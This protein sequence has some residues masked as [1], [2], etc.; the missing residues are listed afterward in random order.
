MPHSYFSRMVRGQDGV[1][2]QPPRPISTLWKSARIDWLTSL[3][4]PSEIA[5][6][7]SSVVSPRALAG[8]FPTRPPASRPTAAEGRTAPAPGPSDERPQEAES[9]GEP[10][11]ARK[12]LPALV[13]VE[14]PQSGART[15]VVAASSPRERPPSTSAPNSLPTS[16]FPARAKSVSTREQASGQD[17]RV[18]QLLPTPRKVPPSVRPRPLEPAATTFKRLP[19]A[20]PS[21]PATEHYSADFTAPAK[22]RAEA[23]TPA[24]E[25]V[26]PERPLSRRPSDSASGAASKS[27]TASAE[28][29][30]VEIGKLEVQVIAPPPRPSLPP[31]PVA[32][33]RL[34]RGYALWPGF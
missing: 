32:K 25:P 12:L 9:R 29:N 17:D 10:R 20:P 33:A 18:T 13:P 8:Q 26:P 3:S 19:A 6:R 16:P 27:Q 2:L 28:R 7:A 15:S 11:E 24:L 21:I 31:A 4:A 23:R 14:P 22:S 34:A 5:P 30:K 1:V